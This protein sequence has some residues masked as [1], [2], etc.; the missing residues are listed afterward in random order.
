MKHRSDHLPDAAEGASRLRQHERDCVECRE[1]DAVDVATVARF[2]SSQTAVVDTSTML[3]A[4][5]RALRD[6]HAHARA[7]V[8]RRRTVQRAAIAALPLPLVLAYAGIVVRAV[9]ME[10]A[11]MLNPELAG[12]VVAVHVSLLTLLFGATYAMIPMF[13]DRADRARPQLVRSSG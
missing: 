4:A 9:Y 13:L 6:E 8:L 12:Y 11:A 10:L 2:L 3:V 7:A 5:R 1:G